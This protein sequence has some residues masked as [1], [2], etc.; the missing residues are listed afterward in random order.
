[1]AKLKGKATKPVRKTARA[2]NKV[3]GILLSLT[4]KGRKEEIYFRVYAKDHRS[5]IDYR[6]TSD[7]M[8]QI[9]DPAGSFVLIN[10][11]YGPRLDY[12]QKALGRE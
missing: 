11:E 1:M 5:W 8:V 9:D 2:A 6:I 10:D 4:K 7:P 12:S 3:R